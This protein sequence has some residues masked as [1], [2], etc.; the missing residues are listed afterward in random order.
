MLGAAGVY[1]IG[2]GMTSDDLRAPPS[3]LAAEPRNLR[4]PKQPKTG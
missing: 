1:V 4:C 3:H 2:G